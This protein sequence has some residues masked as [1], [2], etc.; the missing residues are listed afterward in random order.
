VAAHFGLGRGLQGDAGGAYGYPV[1]VD[2]GDRG[3][4]SGL[5]RGG[6]DQDERKEE[7]THAVVGVFYGGMRATQRRFVDG[8]RSL[9]LRRRLQS[10][11]YR[12]W[13]GAVGRQM[14]LGIKGLG[15]KAFGT[16]CRAS[17]KW[18]NPADF[19]F[20]GNQVN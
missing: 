4:G 19:L 5:G 7:S 14:A 15:W 13:R 17:Y 6:A 9:Q 1:F 3:G 20:K 2:D 10:W 8:N 12:R 11:K 18:E 16:Y